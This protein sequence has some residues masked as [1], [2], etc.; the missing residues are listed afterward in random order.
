MKDSK[1]KL[2]DEV[3]KNSAV[4]TNESY[5]DKKIIQILLQNNI[6]SNRKISVSEIK[7]ISQL[8]TKEYHDEYEGIS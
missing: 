7:E 6:K 4:L 1:D 2:D 3:A 5:F 8:L